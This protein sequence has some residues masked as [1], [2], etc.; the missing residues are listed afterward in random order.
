MNPIPTIFFGA[1]HGTDMDRYKT[2]EV[3]HMAAIPTKC[4]TESPIQT[5]S[6]W[7][8]LGGYTSINHGLHS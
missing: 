6:P 4:D 8:V 2:T 1:K 3:S 7:F 5:N